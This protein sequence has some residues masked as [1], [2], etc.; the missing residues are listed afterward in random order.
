ML[1]RNARVWPSRTRQAADGGLAAVPVTDVRITGD[2]VAECAPGLRAAPGEEDID[3]DGCALLPGM[4]DHHIHLRALAAAQASVPVGP[5]QVRNAEDLRT[6]LSAADAASPKDAWLR[7]VGYHESVAGLL[8]R[9]TLDRLLPHRPVRVQHRAG[10]LWMVNSLAAARLGLDGCNAAGVE[11]DSDGEP[12]GRLWRMDRWLADRVPSAP[13]DL[14]AVSARA[15]AL[16]VTGFTEATP[17]ATQRDIV[18]L[19]QA[20]ADGT[21]VQRVHCMAPFDVP[22]PCQG[23]EQTFS[24]GPVKILLDDDSLP[25]LAELAHHMRQAHAAG[26][27][28]A[29]HCVTRV[30][31]FLT[32]AALQAAGRLPGD[33]IEHGAVIPSGAI[34][35]LRGIT[36]VTQPHFVAER[37]EQYATEVPAEE[38]PDLWRLRTLVDGGVALAA[39]SDAPFGGADPWHIMRT[40]I[41][42]PRNLAPGEALAPHQA[43]RL[44]LGGAG[45][46]A[47]PRLITPGR[48]AD[49]I[50][51]RCPLEEAV[52][53]FSSDV[54]AATFVGGELVYSREH[55]SSNAPG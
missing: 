52:S 11:R 36:V 41:R 28:V 39:G 26:R 54:V 27:P 20:V 48:A 15:A 42:R 44:F 7:C 16:G 38:L 10:S 1:I 24:L 55:G 13:P 22:A 32:L 53:S 33:R 25:P 40:A 21:L 2:R 4:H 30:Q 3:A 5:P 49:L 29:V 37:G 47:T 35:D 50:L 46:P 8:D 9:W 19:A 43:L 45:A 34:A 18:A 17:D 14:A 12:V 23:G 31:L 51:L 6:A